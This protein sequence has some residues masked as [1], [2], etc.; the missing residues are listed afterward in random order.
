[1]HRIRLNVTGYIDEVSSISLDPWEE[2]Y[3]FAEPDNDIP[4]IAT[5]LKTTEI[6]QYDTLDIPIVIY[7]NDST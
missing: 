6:T 7:I 4:I 5:S 3:I 1:V 2:E